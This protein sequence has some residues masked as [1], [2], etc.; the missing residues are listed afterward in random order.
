MTCFESEKG[1]QRA[2]TEPA[3]LIGSGTANYMYSVSFRDES[4]ASIVELRSRK[5]IWG[6]LQASEEEIEQSL[7]E[8]AVVTARTAE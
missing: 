1:L 7:R 6:G 3:T 8:C 4:G 5:T 2:F